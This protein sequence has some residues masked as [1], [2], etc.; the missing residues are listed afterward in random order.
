MRTI[1]PE[2]IAIPAGFSTPQH[3]F[4]NCKTLLNKNIK[5]LKHQ[6]HGIRT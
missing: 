5:Q 4:Y 6:Q 2:L 1:Q 3:P